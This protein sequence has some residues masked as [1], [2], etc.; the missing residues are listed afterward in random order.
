M[1][2]LRRVRLHA[3]H[4]SE[5]T[6]GLFELTLEHEGRPEPRLQ[7]RIIRRFRQRRAI[8]G[9]C[10]F[11]VS[12]RLCQAPL[13]EQQARELR[14]DL[15]DSRERSC[16]FREHALATIR[17]RQAELCGGVARLHLERGV[18]LLDRFVETSALELGRAEQT[19]NLRSDLDVLLGFDE[20]G[21]RLSRPARVGV[22][23]RER[24]VCTNCGRVECNRIAEMPYGILAL[25]ERC[26][27]L[28]LPDLDVRIDRLRGAQ[29]R[30]QL[31][32]VFRLIHREQSLRGPQLRLDD[33][34][35]LSGS[36]HGS[37]RWDL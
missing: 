23:D 32:G 25:A 8:A 6:F 13:L 20:N 2:C 26:G 7:S 35:G 11:G 18:E 31:V 17:F 21:N 37:T 15:F 36:V 24:H 12:A 34:A 19:P 27:D 5:K 30:Q 29:V 28:T 3:K 33:H 22:V 4:I 1:L 14:V 9:D 16:C 10:L